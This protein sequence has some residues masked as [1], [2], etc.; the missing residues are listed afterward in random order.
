MMSEPKGLYCASADR[1]RAATGPPLG[2]NTTIY[3]LIRVRMYLYRRLGWAPALIKVTCFSHV[4]EAF[5]PS[6]VP[7][8]LVTVTYYH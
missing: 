2:C 5:M 4:T 1:L 6:R 8:P 3:N 7:L